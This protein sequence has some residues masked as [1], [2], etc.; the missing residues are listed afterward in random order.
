MQV[1]KILRLLKRHCVQSMLI[2]KKLQVQ[3]ACFQVIHRDLAARNILLG[4]GYVAKVADFGLARDVY[5][6]QKYVKK[7]SVSVVYSIMLETMCFLLVKRPFLNSSCIHHFNQC[8]SSSRPYCLSGGW[9]L[10]PSS[11]QSL[12]RRQMCKLKFSL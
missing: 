8:V 5:K 10:S 4:N 3:F 12:Q 11:T 6:Y 9:Q 1:W 2:E 7:S